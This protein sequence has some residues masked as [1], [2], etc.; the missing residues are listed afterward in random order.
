MS[1]PIKAVSGRACVSLIHVLVFAGLL[2]LPACQSVNP[3]PGFG[4]AKRT[5]EENRIRELMKWHSGKVEIYKDFRT[6][7][8]ARAIFISDEIRKSV[9]D[10]EAK[11]RLMS[12]DEKAKFK[13][14]TFK[15]EKNAYQVL[16]GFYTPENDLNDLEKENS[17][18]IAY[19]VGQDGKVAK[20]SCFEVDVE[21]SKTYMRFL[22]WDLSW[23]RLYMLCFPVGSLDEF[24]LDGWVKLVI[25]GLTGQG[26]IPLRTSNPPQ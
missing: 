20:A 5:P 6:V 22:E 2:F 7:F 26:E 10:W 12:P 21:E 19:L 15:G 18:W 24:Q 23:S 11:S 25:S 13:E 16:L 14:N 4:L 3:L 8:T 9:V 17:S 1:D